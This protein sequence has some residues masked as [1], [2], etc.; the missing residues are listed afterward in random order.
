MT[1]NNARRNGA[2]TIGRAGSVMVRVK[3]PQ[4]L[5][6]G[7]V[8]IV[9]GIAGIV[10]GNHL[11]MGTTARMGPG[12]FPMLLSG[13]II[14]IGLITAARGLSVDGPPIDRFHLRPLVFILAA[15]IASGY[16]LNA[17]GLALTSII[18]TL[19]AAYARRDVNLLETLVL[20]AGIGLFAILVFVYALNQPLPAWWGR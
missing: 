18:V 11:P 3:S 8:F 2:L 13:L 17:A 1:N 20:G 6:A 16:L 4:D 7:V 15:I 12:Y 9:I 14:F 5:G 10:F 19:L